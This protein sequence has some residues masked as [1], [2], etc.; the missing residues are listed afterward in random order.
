MVT[1]LVLRK[2][3]QEDHHECKPSLGCIATPCF[4]ITTKRR[5]GGLR[6]RKVRKNEINGPEI[7]CMW[8][9][10]LVILAPRGLR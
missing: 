4:K 1:I 10:R 5:K 3:R 9:Y 2:L 6:R 7:I 8:M